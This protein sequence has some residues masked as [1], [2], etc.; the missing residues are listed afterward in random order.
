LLTN[1]PDYQIT[2][3]FQIWEKQNI[4]QSGPSTNKAN[5]LSK[6]SKIETTNHPD[7]KPSGQKII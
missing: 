3:V 1:H 2:P 7:Q 4:Q 5:T 6:Q